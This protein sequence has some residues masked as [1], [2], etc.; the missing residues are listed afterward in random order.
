MDVPRGRVVFDQP[1]SQSI[2]YID[3]CYFSDDKVIQKII[4]R[5]EI[6]KYVVKTDIHYQCPNCLGDIWSD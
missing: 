2:I 5:F 3:K 1:N 6:N 4:K